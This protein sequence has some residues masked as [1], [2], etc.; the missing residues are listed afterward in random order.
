M[1]SPAQWLCL[2]VQVHKLINMWVVYLVWK[3]LGRSPL[4]T[5]KWICLSHAAL[6]YS[7]QLSQTSSINYILEICNGASSDETAFKPLWHNYLYSILEHLYKNVTLGNLQTAGESINQLHKL[8]F[9]GDFKR[10]FQYQFY[11]NMAPI[12]N[13]A[14]TCSPVLFSTFLKKIPHFP[15]SANLKDALSSVLVPVIT[16]KYREN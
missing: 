10:A 4:Q 2:A 3:E 1:H 11:F 5:K 14:T 12:S 6:K 8:S 9:D 7:S 16:N 13:C 15:F